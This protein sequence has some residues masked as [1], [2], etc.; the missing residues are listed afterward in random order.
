[1]PRFHRLK[2]SSVRLWLLL[3]SR[4]EERIRLVTGWACLLLSVA[5]VHVDNAVALAEVLGMASMLWRFRWL[6]RLQSRL[7]TPRP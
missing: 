1:M 7:A 3:G 5:D 6:G 4:V 2:E